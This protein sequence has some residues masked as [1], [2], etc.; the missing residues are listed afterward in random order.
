MP[1][2]PKTST[3]QRLNAKGNGKTRS[4]E[5]R[6]RP[7]AWSARLLTYADL[8]PVRASCVMPSGSHVCGGAEV[9]LSVERTEFVFHLPQ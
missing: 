3:R 8:L 6:L 5:M 1:R 2:S 9:P 4:P 7:P